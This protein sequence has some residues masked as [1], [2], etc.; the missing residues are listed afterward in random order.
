[1]LTTSPFL[2]PAAGGRS[3]NLGHCPAGVAQALHEARCARVPGELACSGQVLWIS[4]GPHSSAAGRQRVPEE[5]DRIP[6]SSCRWLFVA[7]GLSLWTGFPRVPLHAVHSTLLRP[8]LHPRTV[9]I[10]NMVCV[11][12]NSS[13]AHPLSRFHSDCCHELLGHMPLLANPSFA[14]FSQ[15][16]GL[17][18]L[19]ASE[20]DIS[21]LATVRNVNFTEPRGSY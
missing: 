9:I 1:M 10:L 16:I 7:A 14:Q 21:K 4:R 5:E 3:E 12:N 18:S 20:D 11:N 19:G 15:E 8:L 17:A 2:S 13:F 6:D